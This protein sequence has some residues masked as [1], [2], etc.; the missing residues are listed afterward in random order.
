MRDD[1]MREAMVL[2][3]GIFAQTEKKLLVRK[4][5]HARD[6]KRARGERVEGIKPYG[7]LLGKADVLAIIRRGRRG[8]R[9]FAAIAQELNAQFHRT[10]GRRDQPSH[11]WTAADVRDIWLRRQ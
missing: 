5:R 3:Q 11:P 8:R 4:M 2:M 10:R 9:T 1:P 6:A 7:T